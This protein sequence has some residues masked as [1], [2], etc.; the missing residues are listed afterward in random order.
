MKLKAGR[1][2]FPALFTLEPLLEILKR[3]SLL[4]TP[5]LIG[6]TTLVLILLLP[7]TVILFTICWHFGAL[8]QVRT[9]ALSL[10]GTCTSSYTI[11]ASY[12]VV[13]LREIWGLLFRGAPEPDGARPRAASPKVQSYRLRLYFLVRYVGTIP[14]S[15]AS[16]SRQSILF[17][18]HEKAR[19]RGLDLAPAIG[20]SVPG[21]SLAVCL[22]VEATGTAPVS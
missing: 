21:L 19:G 10:R 13:K 12:P 9:D 3:L 22:L 14:E 1:M 8:N 11:R 2:I 5:P 18:P 7:Q 20:Q 16:L 15:S 17:R 4:G 6:S